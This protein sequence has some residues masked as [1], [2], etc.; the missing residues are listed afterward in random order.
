VPTRLLDW[1][2]SPSV[3][4]FFAVWGNDDED[5]GLYIIPRPAE[6]PA[7]AASPFEMGKVHFFYPGYVTSGWSR[8]A[9]FSP[10]TRRRPNPTCPPVCSRS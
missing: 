5:A 10:C 7:L 2:E 1:S 4:L 3:S 6:V 8:S 9:A